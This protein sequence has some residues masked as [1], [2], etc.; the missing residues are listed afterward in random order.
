MATARKLDQTHLN[1]HLVTDPAEF[2]DLYAAIGYGTCMEPELRNG[3]CFVFQKSASVSPGD[4][5]GVW[6]KPEHVSPG[7]PQQWLKRLVMGGP[8]DMEYPCLRR[9]ELEFV[10]VV[11]QLNPPRLFQIKCS[12]ILALHRCIGVA[13]R[14]AEGRAVIRRSMIQTT[15]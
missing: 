3:D 2:S 10:I 4:I 5:V 8:P 11:E 14:D 7:R 6:W 15:D 12:Q 1:S 9:G 13:E